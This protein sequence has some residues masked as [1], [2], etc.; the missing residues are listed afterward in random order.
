MNIQLKK[1]GL[2]EEEMKDL[3]NRGFGIPKKMQRTMLEMHSTVLPLDEHENYLFKQ[4]NV[5]KDYKEF[6]LENN[7]GIPIENVFKT[8]SN[9]R[10]VNCFLALMAPRGFEDSIGKYLEKYKDRIPENLLP[11]ASAGS[12]DLVLVGANGLDGVYYWDHNLESDEDDASN[13]YEN[14]EKV[15]NSFSEFLHLLHDPEK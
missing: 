15:A 9:E 14:I 5:P 13:Y 4:F 8:I 1:L 10:V 11:I 2:S 6:L 3:E 12:S 7:G